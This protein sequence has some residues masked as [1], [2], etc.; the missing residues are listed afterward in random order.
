M[1]NIKLL[2]LNPGKT[3]QSISEINN[4]TGLIAFYLP[5]SLAIF[6]DLCVV[7]IPN[8]DNSNLKDIFKNLNVEKYDAILTLGLRFYSTIS[9]HTTLSLRDRF[10][11]LFCQIHDGTR[12]DYDPV[13]ITF[14]LKDDGPRLSDN[15]G[16]FTRHNKYNEY[17]GWA[18]CPQLNTPSQ[19]TKDLRILVDHT[20]YGNNPID[21]THKVLDEIK[22]FVQSNLWKKYFDSISVRRLE[23][24]RVETVDLNCR[25]ITKY[26]RTPIPLNIIAKEYSA[27]HFFCVTHPESVG[28]VTLETSMAGAL[29]LIPLGFIPKD[30]LIT[31]RHLEWQ[32][33]IPWET[34]L[35]KIDINASRH[36]ALENTWDSVAARIIQALTR[37]LDENDAIVK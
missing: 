25:N 13:D 7:N 17:M 1:S 5:K 21:L 3:P 32:D 8:S 29:P 12:L 9:N 31:I 2:I 30:R 26:D 23:S 33:E 37:R 22:K 35:T 24:G 20:N 34:A 36:I 14:T 16:W 28:M 6:C 27:A 10:T 18:A 19:N 11:G 4:F 15:L